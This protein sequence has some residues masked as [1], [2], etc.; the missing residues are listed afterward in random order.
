[1]QDDRAHFIGVDLGTSACKV[2]VFGPCGER[3]ALGRA[4]YPTHRSPGTG[5]AEQEPD[6]WWRALA[7]AVRAAMATVRGNLGHD[8]RVHALGISAQMGTHVLVSGAGKPLGPAVTWQDTRAYPDAAHLNNQAETS[9]AH[10]LG[11]WLPLGANWPAP[12]LAWFRRTCLSVLRQARW[13]WQPR[14][15]LLYRL[16]GTVAT[17]PSSSR[18]MAHLPS[19]ELPLP[20]F[21]LLGV[22]SGIW[23]PIV[24]STAIA[25]YLLPEPAELLGLPT[26]LPVVTGCNDF[27]AALIG[28]GVVSP[29]QG[30]VVTG[31]SEHT[32]V[33]A[34]GEASRAPGLMDVPVSRGLRQVYGA[35]AASGSSLAWASQVLVPK[36]GPCEEATS[37]TT[38]ARSASPA[39]SRPIFL[40][41]LHGERAPIWDPLALGAWVGLSA[42]H[43]AAT[44]ALSVLE[45][46]AFSSRH[47]L[48]HVTAVAAAPDE[49]RLCGGGTPDRAWVTMRASILEQPITLTCEPEAGSLGAAILAAVGIGAQP[50]VTEAAAQMVRTLAV[51]RPDPGQVDQAQTRYEVYKTLFPALRSSM[52]RL[53]RKGDSDDSTPA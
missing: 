52:H 49:M 46:I 45:G 50:S 12:R 51:V 7:Q 35:T 44:L 23:P 11:M 48:E 16:T 38:L 36:D 43:T 30:F 41:Y 26:G 40:P 10:W 13:V 32:G 3:I 2:G 15:Y 5:V 19:G 33:L 37:L 8:A 29:G 28:A 24:P 17:D 27:T 34:A 47:V 18:G 42:E 4:S 1:M 31:T 14:D 6:H 9:I 20:L 25:G 21:E 39:G 53:S 22:S